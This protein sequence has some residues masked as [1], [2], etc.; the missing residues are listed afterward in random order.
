MP[1]CQLLFDAIARTF[2]DHPSLRPAMRQQWLQALD[3]SKLLTRLKAPAIATSEWYIDHGLWVQLGQEMN[4]R[5]AEELRREDAE[6]RSRAMDGLEGC[7]WIRCPLYEWG[8]GIFGREMMGCSR[9]HK[10]RRTTRFALST[11][12]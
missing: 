8:L 2:T 9:C 12:S 7:C 1:E 11:K 4:L 10:V 6:E 3:N 5:P